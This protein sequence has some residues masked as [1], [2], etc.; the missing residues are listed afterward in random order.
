MFLVTDGAPTDSW[1]QAAARVREG[2]SAGRKSFSFFAV[3]VEGADMATLTQICA[4]ER[5]PLKLQGL[6]LPRAVHLA[7]QLARRRG[8]EPAGPAGGAA[9]ADRLA[10]GRLTRGGEPAGLAHGI[11]LGR[12]HLA[13]AYG[14]STARMPGAARCVLAADGTE[15]LVASVADGAGSAAQSEHGARLVVEAFQREF[16]EAARAAPDLGFLDAAFARAW[17][18][19]MQA[20]D[21]P[22]WRPRAA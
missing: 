9:A 20:R 6:Q 10:L 22:A 1:R 16:A 2:D 11:R 21:R 19:R 17:L 4:A 13:R 15:V 3:G 18:V 8:E 5:P 12:R 7:V 14:R